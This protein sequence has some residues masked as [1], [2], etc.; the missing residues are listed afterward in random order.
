MRKFLTMLLRSW[1]ASPIKIILTMLTVAFGTAILM[2]SFSIS[3]VLETE[4]SEALKSQGVTLYGANGTWDAEGKI[5]QERPSQWDG[6]APGYL[7]SDMDGITA[8]S[9]VSKLPF[10]QVTTEGVSYTLRDAVGAEPDYFT[11]FGLELLSG[12]PMSAAD[13]SIGAKKMWI[14]EETAQMLYGSAEQA[15]GKAITPPGFVTNK[16]LREGTQ[17]VLTSYTVTGVYR[18][19]SE[20]ARKAYGIGDIIVPYTAVIPSGMNSSMAKS[21]MAGMLVLRV[22]GSSV[23]EAQSMIRQIMENQYGDDTAV[24]VWEGSVS[25]TSSYMEELR[26]TVSLFTQSV[27][28]L[29]LVLLVVSSMG[30]FSIMVVESL[31]RRREIALERALGASRRSVL[32]E[33]FSWSLMLSAIGALLGTILAYFTAPAVLGTLAPLVGELSSELAATASLQMSAVVSAVLLVLVIGGGFGIIP[34]L[35]VVREHIAET[36]REA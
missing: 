14:S 11:V 9:I 28:I 26:N 8:V 36:L 20:I 24:T 6:D 22:E 23:E 12:D 5:E 31:S 10:S 27:Q 17:P 3:D 13:L 4:V 19:E 33:F 34:A 25:G 2:L 29:G 1:A 18:I 30:I 35:P 32:I 7:R 21:M 15:I 16:N